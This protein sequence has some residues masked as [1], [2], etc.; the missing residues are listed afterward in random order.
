MM[1][2]GNSNMNNGIDSMN[3]ISWMT[4]IDRSSFYERKVILK[5]K[6]VS[7]SSLQLAKYLYKI[8]ISCPCALSLQSLVQ[9]TSAF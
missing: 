4:I 9:T 2:I 5:M 1:N 8:L 7:W 3:N 6:N